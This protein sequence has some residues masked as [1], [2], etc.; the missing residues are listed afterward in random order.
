VTGRI[1]RV[2][3]EPGRVDLPALRA[4]MR[5]P[6][7]VPGR[8]H[9]NRLFRLGPRWNNVAGASVDPDTPGESLFDLALPIAFR[10]DL[11]DHH[12]HPALLDSATSFARD[13]E[14]DPFHLPFMYREL[15]VHA[16]LPAELHSHIRRRHDA[17]TGTIVADVDLIAPDGSVVAQVRGYTMRAVT[18]GSFLPEPSTT[19]EPGGADPGGADPAWHGSTGIVPHV[20]ARMLL[21]LLGVRTPRQV[22]V[23]PFR[24][25]RPVPLPARA[26]G[27]T[28]EPVQ[29]PASRPGVQ[30]PETTTAP[31]PSVAAPHIAPG[32]DDTQ[33]LLELWRNAL[34][35]EDL[36]ENADFFELGGNSLMAVDLMSKIR[37]TFGIDLSIA[38]LFDH[39]TVA[40]LSAELRRLGTD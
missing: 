37:D 14:T 35:T 12:L 22:V 15:T 26:P 13:P 36:G 4:R 34:G 18:D 20:G 10:G 40:A 29:Q 19:G 6:R 31:E 39:P 38:A 32:T 2:E 23:R 3:V 27:S 21:D 5:R 8:S 24:D 16:A 11:D 1:G 28:G 25:A 33:R 30:L 17:P 7:T 9:P